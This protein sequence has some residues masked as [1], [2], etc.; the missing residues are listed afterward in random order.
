MSEAFSNEIRALVSDVETEIA[1]LDE[2]E[3]AN[4][5]TCFRDAHEALQDASQLIRDLETYFK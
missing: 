5:E 2:I 4:M 3:L 1:H